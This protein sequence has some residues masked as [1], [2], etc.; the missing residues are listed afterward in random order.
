M[1]DDPHT[2]PAASRRRTP[3]R[4][5]L[6]WA[7]YDWANSAYASVVQT[8][9]FAAYFTESVA[10]S[11][12][13]GTAMWG[14]TVGAAGLLVA[15]GG[16]L[17]G[18]VAD[19]GGRRKPWLAG[20]TGL[21]VAAT[22]GLWFVE[23]STGSLALALGLI[24]VGTVGAEFAVVFYNA[25]L[26]ELAPPGRVGRWSGW[27]WALGY[28]GGLACLV[29]ALLGFIREGGGW[30]GV[31]TEQAEHVRATFPLTAGWYLLFAL[32]L[33]FLT[34]D[35]PATGKRMGRAVRDGLRQIAESV[36]N[37]RRYGHIVRF[38]IARMIF[39]DGLATTFAFGGIYAAG[40]FGMDQQRVLLFGIGLSV[41]A[42]LGA[43]AFAWIDD[44][45]GPKRTILI[46]LAALIA[47]TAG[48]LFVT[49]EPLFWAIGLLLGLF[50]GP[51]QAASRSY[52]AHAA[53]EALRNQMFGLYALSGKATAFLGP[54]LVGWITSL[55]GSQRVGMGTIVV[56]FVLGFLLMLT[57]PNVRAEPGA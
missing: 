29:L 32:P 55:A 2:A 53:P 18:A 38:L 24:V 44:W 46:S 41:T 15:V 10:A 49:S 6:A 20:F 11:S 54:V 14:Y 35:T 52:L 47:T 3:T 4:G 30:F 19:Q 1:P 57:V 25:M 45:I 40:A 33:F 27:G 39:A 13:A 42:G 31:G 26:P 34:P 5:L 12:E 9:V 22:T 8:F 50:V 17:L 48:I 16:P 28:A 23:P 36:R 51:A 21:C 7:V 43:A 37:V 56:F